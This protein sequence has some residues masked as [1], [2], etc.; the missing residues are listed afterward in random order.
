MIAIVNGVGVGPVCPVA[1]ISNPNP[2]AIFSPRTSD[3]LGY[4]GQL[5]AGGEAPPNCWEGATAQGFGTHVSSSGKNTNALIRSAGNG[6]INAS[7]TGVAAPAGTILPTTGVTLTPCGDTDN[8]LTDFPPIANGLKGQINWVLHNGQQILTKATTTTLNAPADYTPV[9]CASLNPAGPTVI[10]AFSQPTIAQ[11]AGGGSVTDTLTITV[12]PSTNP[13]STLFNVNVDLSGVAGASTTAPLTPSSIG[14]PDTFGNITFQELITIPTTTVGTFT[15]PVT[16]LDDAYRAAV[17]ANNS[18]PLNAIVMVGSACQVPVATAQTLQLGWNA[19]HAITL[20][21]QVGQNCNSSDTLTY[22]VQSQPLNGTLSLAS[23]NSITYTPNAGFSGL[24]SFTYNLTDTS[25]SA[26]PLTGPIATVGLVVS[27]SGV[28]PVLTLT[29]PAATYDTSF[30]GCTT[31][32]TP[33]VAGTTTVTYN[34]S[35]TAPSAAGSYPVTANFVSTASSTQNTSAT[36][37]L[38]I[39]QATP[40]LKL[41]CPTLPFTGSPQGCTTSVADVGT[42]APAG[43]TISITY[44]GSSTPPTNGATYTVLAS[45]T[46]ADPNYANATATSSLTIYEPLVTITANSQTITYGGALPTFTYTVSPSIP[47]QTNPVC[48]SSTT[49]ASNVGIYAGA[50]TCSGAAKIGVLFTYVAGSM[51]VLP[52]AATVTANNQTMVA[53]AVVPALTYTTTPASLTFT[54]TPKCTTTATS[55]SPAGTY[56]ISCAGAVASNYNLTYVAGTMTISVAP[57]TPNSIPTITSMLPMS[58]TAGAAA[59]VVL[60]VTGGSFV[61]GATSSLEWL[62]TGNNLRECPPS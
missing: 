37:Q 49:G 7:V 17:N 5:S 12:T 10:A 47:L 38:V 48:T 35:P 43:G 25:N 57:T 15:F 30:H 41:L 33:F 27:A 6:K 19:P 40:T 50:I 42:A 3:F 29:C 16:V 14:V 53:G 44:N 4:F 45:F 55:S 61:S 9:P 56:P 54:T 34:G 24:D 22:A 1:T 60:T 8:N 36:G 39:S 11:G 23:G 18:T 59:N 31:T 2:S 51:T 58:A 32:L 28:T 21:G 20:A 13:T 26:G 52:A 46:S 62:D